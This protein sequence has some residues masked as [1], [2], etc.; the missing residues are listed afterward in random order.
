MD[1]DN[2]PNI[3]KYLSGEIAHVS[4]DVSEGSFYS[5]ISDFGIGAEGIYFIF[6]SLKVVFPH[7]DAAFKQLLRDI[8][9][10]Q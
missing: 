8:I 6:E 5:G 3:R 7:D 1:S 10:E 9:G 2:L 4:I